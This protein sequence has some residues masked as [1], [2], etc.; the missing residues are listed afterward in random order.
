MCGRCSPSYFHRFYK[1]HERRCEPIAMTVPRKVMLPCPFLGP[2]PGTDLAR[3]QGG[4][5]AQALS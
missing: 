4:G 5:V 2:G 3:L 1:L